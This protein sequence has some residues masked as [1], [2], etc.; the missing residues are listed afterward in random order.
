MSKEEIKL[1]LDDEETGLSRETSHPNFTEHFSAEFY[2]DCADDECIGIKD[3]LQVSDKEKFKN[4]IKEIVF[5]KD[6][7]INNEVCPYGME[8]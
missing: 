6:V 1:Y 7:F 4:K 3:L 8:R 2:Y 5:D